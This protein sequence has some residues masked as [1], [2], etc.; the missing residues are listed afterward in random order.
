MARRW[1]YRNILRHISSLEL[2]Q[3]DNDNRLTDED[4]Y[5]DLSANR[6][7]SLF[8]GQ[9]SRRGSMFVLERLG[10]FSYMAELGLDNPAVHIDTSQPFRH[11]FRLMHADENRE[12][13]ITEAVMR[14]GTF[15]FSRGKDRQKSKEIFSILALEWLLMQNPL[16]TF[17]YR[18]P[19]LPSQEYPGLGLAREAFEIFYWLARRRKVDGVLIIPD[20]LHTAIIYSREFLFP[21]PQYQAMILQVRQTLLRR[22]NLAQVSWAC[23]EQKITNVVYGST[24]KWE[25]SEMLLPVSKRLHDYFYSRRYRRN[26]TRQRDKYRFEIERGYQKQF[27]PDWRGAP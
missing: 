20:S 7:T 6:G 11:L 16:G 22:R 8:L 5:L 27:T 13:L 21:D 19:Q 9:Y 2:I 3:P 26:V 12:L 14:E 1:K 23:Q 17:T 18:R 25:P 24:F 10:L 4:F 15:K